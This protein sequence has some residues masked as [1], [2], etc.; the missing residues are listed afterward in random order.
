M[1]FAGGRNHKHEYART[2]AQH[3]L[4]TTIAYAEG[5]GRQIIGIRQRELDRVGTIVLTPGMRAYL[6]ASKLDMG[7]YYVVVQLNDKWFSSCRDERVAARQIEQV[8]AYRTSK[9]A[10]AA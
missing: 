1:S 5:A 4:D 10:S 7:R 2:I 6:V 8:K 3:V 9:V